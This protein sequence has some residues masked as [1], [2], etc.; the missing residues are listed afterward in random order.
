MKLNQAKARNQLG[1]DGDNRVATVTL[2][3]DLPDLHPHEDL[4]VATTVTTLRDAVREH[5][6]HAAVCSLCK[7]RDAMRGTYSWYWN[8]TPVPP[9]LMNQMEDE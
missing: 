3:V 4:G 2:T 6:D 9:W 7:Q 8:P 1:R 5:G